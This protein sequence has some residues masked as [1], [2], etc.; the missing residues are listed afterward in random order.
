MSKYENKDEEFA[1]YHQKKLLGL[2]TPDVEEK[3]DYENYHKEYYEK[4]KE[5]IKAQ[6]L[7]SYHDKRKGVSNGSKTTKG[8]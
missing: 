1:Y 8:I 3:V 7:K 4:N 5:K 2:I 6:N